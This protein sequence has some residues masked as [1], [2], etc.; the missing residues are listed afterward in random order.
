MI[1]YTSGNILESS[2]DALVNTVN[3]EGIM[4]KGLALQFKKNF[5]TTLK[6]MQKLA[7]KAK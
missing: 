1:H 7:K 4:G 3:T 2:S 5:Q 6:H